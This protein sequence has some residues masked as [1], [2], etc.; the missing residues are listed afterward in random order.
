MARAGSWAWA[1]IALAPAGSR[2]RAT[3]QR[4]SCAWATTA[5]ALLGGAL[6]ERAKNSATLRKRVVVGRQE[7]GVRARRS[8]RDSLGERQGKGRS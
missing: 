8:K 3:R 6:A 5:H 4:Q 2:S 7:T 1:V